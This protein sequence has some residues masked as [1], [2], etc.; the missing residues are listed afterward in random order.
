MLF[1]WGDFLVLLTGI[2]RAVTVWIY[3]DLYEVGVNIN[4]QSWFLTR[5]KKQL[6]DDGYGWIW[7]IY[8]WSG[9]IT[10]RVP[11]RGLLRHNLLETERNVESSIS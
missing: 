8:L 7:W 4:L 6:P 9:S 11:T 3:M 10:Y 5:T 1:L 2:T